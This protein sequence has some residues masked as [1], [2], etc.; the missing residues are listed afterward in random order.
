M[1]K[2]M[3]Q[4]ELAVYRKVC[5]LK[6]VGVRDTRDTPLEAGRGDSEKKGGEGKNL[7]K[8]LIKFGNP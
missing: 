7:G 8:G 6:G 1:L 4:P 2:S 5:K 3:V